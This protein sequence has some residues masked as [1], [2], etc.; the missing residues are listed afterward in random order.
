MRIGTAQALKLDAKDASVKSHLDR[1]K[2]PLHLWAGFDALA[3]YNLSEDVRLIDVYS[4]LL[5]E[6][7]QHFLVSL[8]CVFVSQFFVCA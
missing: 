1:L 6:V 2:Q 5:R 7:S 3:R 8:K 4:I